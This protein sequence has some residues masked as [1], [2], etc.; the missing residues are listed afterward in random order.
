MGAVDEPV[1]DSWVAG[2]T[3]LVTGATDGIG[4]ETALAL[5]RGGATLYLHG[6]DPLRCSKAREDLVATTGAE[7]VH[8]VIADF[9]TLAG[10]RH[11]A[12]EMQQRT[13][14]L[15]VLVNN[16]GV[17]MRRRQLT[18]D[19]LEMTFAVNHIAPYL[20]TALLMPLLMH[21]PSAR[22]ITVS[23]IAHSRA[24]VDFDNL[25]GEKSFN[26]YQAYALSKLGN[27][28]FSLE[29][30]ERLAGTAVSSNTL[31][32]GVIATKLLQ[33][34]FPGSSGASVPRGAATTVFLAS[35]PLLDGVSGQYFVDS[36]PREPSPLARDR[37]L[38]ARFWARS[39]DL[40]GAEPRP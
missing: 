26:P 40:A 35:S 15:D 2:K 19:G 8:T 27:V 18:P 36:A 32:P 9:G 33:E 29:L 37:E 22:V 28:L 25:Q 12:R 34:G 16:A 30:A 7:R 5:A 24:H 31:H 21:A 20:L 14:V 39:A 3:A 4:R 6:R 38:R 13:P 11:C 1:A 17:Y 10:I 23:S